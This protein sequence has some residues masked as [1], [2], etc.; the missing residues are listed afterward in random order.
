MIATRAGYLY[1]THLWLCGVLMFGSGC[2]DE[3][4]RGP[5]FTAEVDES[6]LSAP[7]DLL[8]AVDSSPGDALDSDLTAPPTRDAPDRT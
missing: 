8:E 5:A 6:D 3:D 4:D 2:K 1:S 7:N